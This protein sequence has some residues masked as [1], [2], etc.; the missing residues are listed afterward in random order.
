M[1]FTRT[2]VDACVSPVLALEEVINGDHIASRGLVKEIRRI[3]DSCVFKLIDN[4]I[5]F[6]GVTKDTIRMA[7]PLKGEHTDMVL[8]ELGYSIEEINVFRNSRI[9]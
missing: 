9:I 1:R 5:N 7:P 8:S 6:S 3:S 2:S 4:P